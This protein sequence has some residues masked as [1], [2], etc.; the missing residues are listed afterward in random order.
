MACLFGH[1][2]LH[3]HRP[4]PNDHPEDFLNGEFWKRHRK[5]DNVLSNTIMFLPERLRLPGGLHDRN[6][7]YLNMNIHASTICLHQA[8]ILKAEKHGLDQ[9]I[10]RQSQARCRVSA[11][12]IVKIMRLIRH[13]DISE[14]SKLLLPAMIPLITSTAE[15]LDIIQYIH[16]NWR[17]DRG[18]SFPGDEPRESEQFGFSVV[19]VGSYRKEACCYP[20]IHRPT[21]D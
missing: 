9:R 15:Y 12:E 6:I 5:M 3:L 2:W 11:Q 10:I 14:V 16:C 19:C 7:V 4:G 17:F 8:A 18:M 1:N 21:H 13:F 20:I